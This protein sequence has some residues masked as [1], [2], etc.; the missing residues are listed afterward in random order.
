MLTEALFITNIYSVLYSFMCEYFEYLITQVLFCERSNI[1][2]IFE[3]SLNDHVTPAFVTRYMLRK[4]A[5]NS[6]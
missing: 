3:F 5:Q 6:T 2:V 1:M 4:L